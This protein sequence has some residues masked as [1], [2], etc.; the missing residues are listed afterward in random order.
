MGLFHRPVCMKR[1]HGWDDYTDNVVKV[2]RAVP[3]VSGVEEVFSL[4][5]FSVCSGVDFS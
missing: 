3:S 4:V 5:E 2:C 1:S